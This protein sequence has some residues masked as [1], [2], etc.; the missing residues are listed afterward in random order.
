MNTFISG[1]NNNRNKKRSSKRKFVLGLISLIFGIYSLIWVAMIYLLPFGASHID[2]SNID[3]TNILFAAIFIALG[4][5]LGWLF[6]VLFWFTFIVLAIG[7]SITAICLGA[8]S[9]SVKNNSDSNN[10]PPVSK[11]NSI[12]VPFSVVGL[13]VGIVTIIATIIILAV[14]GESLFI[15]FLNFATF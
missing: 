7:F 9:L 10:N 3:Y 5:V 8:R 1:N 14:F 4:V 11:L 6:L 15:P 13:V 2:L 12:G